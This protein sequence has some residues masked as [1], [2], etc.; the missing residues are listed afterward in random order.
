MTPI[1]IAPSYR[2]HCAMTIAQPQRRRRGSSMW[3]L[4]R[5]SVKMSP[6]SGVEWAKST[7]LRQRTCG[8]GATWA[9]GLG[10]KPCSR[11]T[12]WL[13]RDGSGMCLIPVLPK[14]PKHCLCSIPNSGGGMFPKSSGGMFLVL[15]GT[16]GMRVNQSFLFHTN[17]FV[18]STL[19]KGW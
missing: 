2:V 5:P 4:P 15:A 1:L 9:Q 3:I 19:H 13:H 17:S 16:C 11:T 12:P 18:A 6:T 14:T 8:S 10:T 7:S